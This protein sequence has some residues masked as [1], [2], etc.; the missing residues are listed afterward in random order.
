MAV[1]EEDELP[2]SS[3]GS[4]GKRSNTGWGNVFSK[5]LFRL[6]PDG[7]GGL[8]RGSAPEPEPDP[9][10]WSISKKSVSFSKMMLSR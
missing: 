10:C 4:S 3:D 6:P 2:S 5:S 9:K 1:W 8:T 7:G